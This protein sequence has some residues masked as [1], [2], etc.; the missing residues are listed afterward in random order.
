MLKKILT[1]LFFFAV[2]SCSSSYKLDTKDQTIEEI[3]T[4]LYPAG[5]VSE[6]IRSLFSKDTTTTCVTFEQDILHT[7]KLYQH[8]NYLPFW[9]SK[10][11]VYKG[12]FVIKSSVWHGL[13]PDDYFLPK[14]DSLFSY[15]WTDDF[16]DTL[17]LAYLDVLLTEGIYT[18]CKHLTNGK[19]SALDYHKS[20]NY[21]QALFPA[22]DSV[23]LY[24][25]KEN[26]IDSI[27][28]YFQPKSESYLHM[29]DEYKWLANLK[30]SLS[31]YTR[32]KY[33]GELIRKGDSNL[34]VMQLKQALYERKLINYD[35]IDL[36][37]DD[38]LEQAVKDFQIRHGLIPDGIPGPNTYTF[39]YW[40][41]D[42]Y[43]N[44]L[45][46]NLERIR[47]LPRD[48]P[49]TNLLV[50][51]PSGEILLHNKNQLIFNSRAIVGKLKNQT[52]VFTSEIE[53]LV[54]NPCWTIPESIATKKILFRLKKDSSY[55]DKRNMFITLK[56]KIQEH[57]SIDFS[58]YNES[59]FPFKIYQRSDKNN[60][61]GKV[62][63]MF[64]NP[65][66][67]YLHDTPGKYLFNRDHRTFSH[68]CVRIENALELS[69]IILQNLNNHKNDKS[70]YLNKGFP[71]K[72]YL[73]KTIQINILYLTCSYNSKLKK[74]Q[75]FKDVY[76][77]DNTVLNA[78]NKR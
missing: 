67:I 21:P 5:K 49:N 73:E 58:I 76:N 43:L 46:I 25:I 29:V 18:F 26:K 78:L 6:R 4:I 7:Q 9:T 60:A 38:Q 55:L 37:F 70:Y 57:D 34:F 61:L 39:L 28:P 77:L 56:G 50:N 54:Y 15:C 44:T 35:S 52:P 74:L 42:N 1:I 11:K 33:P 48:L 41:I 72:I 10:H 68:G 23:L 17:A 71:E 59:N 40:K 20:W 16:T 31:E 27:A 14:I 45:K 62:K 19:L 65:Y 2:Y 3:K 13:N 75:Y 63:F 12:M 69:D 47:W 36:K 30:D 51:I 8:N 32:L 22:I 24:L 66:N 53:Y 64:K